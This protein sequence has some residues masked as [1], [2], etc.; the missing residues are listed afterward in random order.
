MNIR[1]FRLLFIL[2]AV[3]M[4]AC[5]KN[6]KSVEITGHRGASGLAPENTMAS[7]V[8]AME[9]TADFSELDVQETADGILV[10]MHDD[11]LQR[12]TGIEAGVWEK[13]YDDLQGL[14]VGFWFSEDFK[15]EPIPTLKSIIEAVRG[16]MKLNI[17]LKMNGHE[18]Q[19]TEKVVA[20]VENEDFF[21]NCVLT[22]F[23][24]S[25]IKKVKQLNSKIKAGYIFSEMPEDE[26]VFNAN[27]DLLS[28]NKKIVTEDLVQKA[29]A[30]NKEVHVWTVNEP[31][32]MRKLISF[33]VDNIITNYPNILKQVLTEK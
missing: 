1:I 18:K 26:D 5:E 22:S 33:G 3:A 20:M 27:V 2:G 4:L 24:F 30:N 23:D 28:V 17:E 25:A 9:L 16:K 14:D 13:T 29:H 32:D 7:M 6:V 19:L 21:D 12:T 10:L 11:S 15:G 31:E 8:K